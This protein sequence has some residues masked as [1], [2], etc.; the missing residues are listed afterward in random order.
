MGGWFTLAGII[1]GGV[2]GGAAGSKVGTKVEESLSEKELDNFR[3]ACEQL[4]LPFPEDYEN[5][6][7]E[8]K[9]RA[10]RSFHDLPEDEQEELRQ[11]MKRELDLEF[12]SE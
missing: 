9:R 7:P 3:W 11:W 5:P 8:W 12:P 6:S 2:I 10:E 1:L 4:S